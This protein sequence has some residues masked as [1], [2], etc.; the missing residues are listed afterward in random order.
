MVCSGPLP[1]RR[2]TPVALRMLHTFRTNER[3]RNYIERHLDELRRQLDV[4]QARHIDAK[5][6]RRIDGQDQRAGS[7]PLVVLESVEGRRYVFKQCDPGLAAAEEAAYE[8]RRLGGR[9]AVPSRAVSLDIEGTGERW[10][11]LKPYVHFEV[12]AELAA[13]TTTWTAEQRAVMVMEHAWEW[14]LDNLDTNTSQYAL[15]GPLA[16]PIN[17]DWDR[18]F[19]SAGRS[20]FSRFAKYRATLPNART[21]LYADYVAGRTNLP[22]WMLSNEARRI[23][24]LSKPSLEAILQKYARVRFEDPEEQR[25]F[26]TRMLIR[27]RGIE[28]EVGTF[29]RSL[30]AERRAL[31]APP[32]SFAEWLHQKRSALWAEWQ[33]VLNAVLR[34]PVG[35]GARR[36]V[37]KLRGMRP[38]VPAEGDVSAEPNRDRPERAPAS[39]G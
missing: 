8:L 5:T 21:F 28:R 38:A 32:G 23:R 6:L 19:F 25:Q 7:K 1:S 10:G 30:W 12:S 22:L 27:Q 13:D 15:L 35:L 3:F 33:V 2:D 11:L 16:L 20:E 29:M 36:L 34:G 39:S 26:V 37:S 18:S 17:I 14:F 31:E 9:P 24:R 4:G